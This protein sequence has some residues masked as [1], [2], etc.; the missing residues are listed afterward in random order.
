MEYMEYL[1]TEL[2]SNPLNIILAILAGYLLWQLLKPPPPPPSPRKEIKIEPRDYTLAELAKFDGKT[3]STEHDGASPIYFA[4]NFTVFD[5]SSRPDFYGADG[6]YGVFA[7]RDASRGLATMNLDPQ[8]AEWDALEGLGNQEKETMEGW[9][10]TF[11]AKYPIRGRLVKEHTAKPA[12]G[13]ADDAELIKCE[14]EQSFKAPLLAAVKAL[15]AVDDSA[16]PSYCSNVIKAEL[17]KGVAVIEFVACSGEACA[18]KSFMV[19]GD[20]ATGFTAVQQK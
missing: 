13:T 17:V 4:V 11:S 8:P 6:P 2:L 14:V 15:N 3:P 19:R 12:D 9:H 16:S 5:V 10:E 1:Q 20:E 18:K 7:G